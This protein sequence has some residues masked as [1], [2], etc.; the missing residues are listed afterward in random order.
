LRHFEEKTFLP[1]PEIKT[2][3]TQH[4]AHSLHY[5]T[6][7]SAFPESVFILYTDISGITYFNP[8]KSS[9][10]LSTTRSNNQNYI[11]TTDCFD[12]SQNKQLLFSYTI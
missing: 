3:I 4:V 10:Y 6:P 12:V 9:G 5:I 8:L 11:L 1:L 2:P 7:V